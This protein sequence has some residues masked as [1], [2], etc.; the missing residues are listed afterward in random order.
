M[1]H[2]KTTTKPVFD[3]EVPPREGLII[4]RRLY[5][6]LASMKPMERKHH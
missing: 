1:K 5:E 3:P 2:E 4:Y 6:A